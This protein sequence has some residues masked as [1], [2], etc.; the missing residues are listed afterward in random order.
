MHEKQS[1]T[2]IIQRFQNK[3]LKDIVDGQW[4]IRNAGLH[5]DLQKEMITY[6]TGKIP[7]KH[8][9]RLLHH[10]NVEAIQLLDKSELVWRLKKKNFWACVVIINHLTPNDH[11]S[12]RT[13]PLTSRCFFF[14]YSTNI[15]TEY[16]K[17]AAYTLFF[18]LQN[19]VYF[20]MP[21]FLVLY[22]SHFIY[23]M[24]SNLK[25]NSGAKGLIPLRFS[26]LYSSLLA[27]SSSFLSSSPAR[28]FT[29]WK[30][31]LYV[32]RWAI[33]A[34]VRLNLYLRYFF[35]CAL[36]QSKADRPL[37]LFELETIWLI[38]RVPRDGTMYFPWVT[39]DT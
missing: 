21:P 17:N 23:R 9:E 15:R 33:K 39:C 14:I 2:D 26:L 20:I 18:P 29:R 1:N 6:E 36:N 16:F 30:T 11:F 5:R 12:G 22:Y 19:A 4:Y 24:C 3:V 28:I 25:E 7:K 37:R 35:T 32:L 38:S 13:A 10:V 27:F 31:N 8:E 34:R